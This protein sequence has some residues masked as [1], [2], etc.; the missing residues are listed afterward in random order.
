MMH[1]DTVWDRRF[2]DTV[3]PLYAVWKQGKCEQSL[4]CIA[5]NISRSFHS[6]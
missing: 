1:V 6:A 3:D 5:L 4:P 2:A